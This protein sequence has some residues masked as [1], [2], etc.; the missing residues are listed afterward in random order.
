[1]LQALA[2]RPS[3]RTTFLYPR[4][5]DCMRD[6]VSRDTRAHR[7]WRP[8]PGELNEFAG[9]P[10]LRRRIRP[11]SRTRLCAVEPPATILQDLDAS[12][13]RFGNRSFD[14]IRKRLRAQQT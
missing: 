11:P 5:C 8:H 13:R 1:M 12:S 6:T 4:S 14:L 9:L 2:D 10:A 7:I 3:L